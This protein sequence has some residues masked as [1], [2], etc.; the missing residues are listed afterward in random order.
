M[1][2]SLGD[3]ELLWRQYNLWVDIYKFHMDLVLKANAFFYLI[4][5]G[6]LS[7][8]FAHT[9]QRLI[10]WS[11]LLPAFMSLVLAVAFAY[12]ARLV[13]LKSKGLTHITMDLNF[14]TGPDMGVLTMLLWAGA[15]IFLIVAIALIFLIAVF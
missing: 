11:L 9:D 14:R 8:Y 13:A 2:D 10:K 5:G 6:I 12:G 3:R 15:T 1:E 7:Y 4:T